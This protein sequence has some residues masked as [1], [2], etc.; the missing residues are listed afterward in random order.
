MSKKDLDPGMVTLSRT[1]A[2]GAANIP[3][4]LPSADKARYRTDARG[5]QVELTGYDY[6][7]QLMAERLKG[8][9]V[10]ASRTDRFRGE[11]REDAIGLEEDLRV[12]KEQ[13]WETPERPRAAAEFIPMDP[14]AAKFA[15]AEEYRWSVFTRTGKAELHRSLHGVNQTTD[16]GEFEEQRKSEI[17]NSTISYGWTTQEEINQPLLS[18]DFGTKRAKAARDAMDEV[19][20][21]L[22]LNGATVGGVTYAGLFTLSGVTTQTSANSWNAADNATQSTLEAIL[23]DIRRTYEAWQDASFHAGTLNNSELPDTVLMS[24]RVFTKLS[25][26]LRVNQFATGS[27]FEHLQVLYPEIKN[28]G[29]H[30]DLREAA[31]ANTD[32]LIMY[33]KDARVLAAALPV[34]Y[35]EQPMIQQPYGSKIFAYSRVAPVEVHD[36]RLIQ[37]LNVDFS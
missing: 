11:I 7:R 35:Q 18:Y 37:Y 24:D 29:V 13:F 25:K 19:H 30:R 4:P 28:W 8:E 27:L 20:D 6:N 3:S 26:E 21:Q 9:L 1:K 12:A 14:E 33:K 2:G 17:L 15:S 22:W 31:G 10:R 23:D 16:V 5:R 34:P 32:R 36:L